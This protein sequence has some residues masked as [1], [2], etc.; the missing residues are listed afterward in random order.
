MENARKLLRMVH[1]D[2]SCLLDNDDQAGQI[3]SAVQA[4]KT[5]R[6]TDQSVLHTA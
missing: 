2:T 4:R 6:A 3:L 1:C 5:G